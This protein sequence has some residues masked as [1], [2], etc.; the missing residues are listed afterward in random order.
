MKVCILILVI[1]M[2]HVHAASFGQQVTLD[3][4]NGH[5]VDVL[6]EIQKQTGYEFLYNNKLIDK[7]KRVT[8][9][10]KNRN[11]K[12]VLQEFLTERNLAYE[13]NLNTVLIVAKPA[14]SNLPQSVARVQ[15]K[16]CWGRFRCKGNALESVTVAVKG[17]SV[18][19]KTD[20]QG[21]Y[22]LEIEDQHKTLVF[23]L[24]GYQPIEQPIG[25]S[26]QVNVTLEAA[27]SDLEE[28]VVVAYGKQRKIS[29]IG[30][31]SSVSP[32]Q[33]K[34]PVA[35]ISSSLAGQMAGVVTVQGSG[36]PGSATSFWIRGVS[37][38][39]GSNSPLILVDG[40]ERPMDLVDPEDVESFSVLKMRQPP[41]SMG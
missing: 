19:T 41:L 5:L 30:A 12:E 9:K 40:I 39:A 37:S 6:D 17:T 34:S 36:E 3:I 38:F 32:Q 11:F 26:T 15:K 2:V 1:S 29:V 22:T 20:A 23:S 14:S 27:V 4:K 24:V 16:D 31:I 13:L 8:I 21:R 10:A 18:A 28:A 33:L 7:Q 25:N 35:K